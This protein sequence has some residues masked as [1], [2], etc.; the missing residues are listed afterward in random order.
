MSDIIEALLDLV[1]DASIE[2]S[3]SEK[4]PKPLR[5]LCILIIAVFYI[6]LVGLMLLLGYTF[7]DTNALL[8]TLFYGIGIILTFYGIYKLKKHFSTKKKSNN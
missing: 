5:I 1:L 4:L 2:G 3:K 8:G 7:Q 6:A